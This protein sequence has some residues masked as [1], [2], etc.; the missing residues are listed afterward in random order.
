MRFSASM[1]LLGLLIE[2]PSYG[3]ELMQRFERL[4]GDALRLSGSRP[5][6]Q[7]LEE[8]QDRG[9]IGQVQV[10]QAPSR[11]PRV[12]YQPT[13][14]GLASY[15]DWLIEQLNQEREN[16][17]LF[18]KRLLMLD[19]RSALEVLDRYEHECLDEVNLAQE[20]ELPRAG[21]GTEGLVHRLSHEDERLTLGVRLS[22]FEFARHE[23]RKLIQRRALGV[24]GAES[25][26]SDRPSDGP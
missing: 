14:K 23:V 6:Y 1:P 10:A 12:H 24:V 20:S 16:A 25:A 3:Y 15:E 17:R 11:R 26:R 18:A 5:V 7:A 19:P 21:E 22:W 13:E 2:R 9:L 4:Y 8:L